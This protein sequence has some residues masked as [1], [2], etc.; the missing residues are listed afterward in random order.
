MDELKLNQKI[1][2]RIA[3]IADIWAS[4]DFVGNF[5]LGWSGGKD[6]TVLLNLTLQ[7]IKMLPEEQ[8]KKRTLYVVMSN[9][10]MENPILDEYAHIQVNLLK[11]YVKQNNLPVEVDMVMRKDAQSFFYLVIGKGYPL[12][13]NTSTRWCTHKLKIEPIN[14]F[15]SDKNICLMFVGSRLDESKRRKRTIEKYNTEDERFV[16]EKSRFGQSS[17]SISKVYSAIQD[18][19]TEEI[20]II[21]SQKLLWGS[22]RDIRNLYKDA[23]GECGVNNPQGAS[24][25]NNN[26]CS[27][28]FGCWTCP[29]ISKDKSTEQMAI[30]YEWLEPLTE[31]RKFMIEGDN[32]EKN[33]QNRS[34]YTRRGICSGFGKG[35]YSL[36]YRKK[37]LDKLLETQ[38][39]CNILRSYMG[40]E[41]VTLIEESEIDFIKNQWLED[42]NN[43]PY[44]NDSFEHNSGDF[45]LGEIAISAH[46]EYLKALKQ[47]KKEPTEENKIIVEKFKELRKQKKFMT[48]ETNEQ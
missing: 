10:M 41:K 7:A 38:K 39:D 45:Q 9:T 16:G 46:N 34:G 12:P 31:F 25:K 20:W 21:L 5:A 37:L 42:F 23:T 6:S 33:P 3:E 48:E 30:K 17:H 4:D 27:A 43:K 11:Q 22:S 8:Q 40:L 32:A 13:K 35:C 28:R 2:S 1:V 44:L 24:T 18:F 26:A 15:L 29:P 36:E 14:N 19:T 47:Y